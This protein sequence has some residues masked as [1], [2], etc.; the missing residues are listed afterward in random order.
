M[1]MYKNI[2]TMNGTTFRAVHGITL[3][4]KNEACEP[5][6]NALLYRIF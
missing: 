6:F 1:I 5:A 3:P 2:G 4:A